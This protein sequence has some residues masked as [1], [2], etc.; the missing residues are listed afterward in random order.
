MKDRDVRSTIA[1]LVLSHI[2]LIILVTMIFGLKHPFHFLY[3]ELFPY[4]YVF[5]ACIMVMPVYIMAG[6][7]FVLAKNNMRKILDSVW[8][9]CS[10][11]SGFLVILWAFSYVMAITGWNREAWTYYI[12]ANYPISF[13]MNHINLAGTATSNPV[14]VLPALVPGISFYLGAKLRVKVLKGVGTGE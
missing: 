14:Y 6:Y 1:I 13:L 5:V 7:I 11:F 3:R 4:P 9:G 12:I 8:T 2:S 10:I